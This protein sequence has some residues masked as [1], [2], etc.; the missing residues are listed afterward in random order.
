MV[1]IADIVLDSPLL[2][3]PLAG[4]TDLP[5]RLLCREFGAGLVFSEMISCHGLVHRQKKT[6]AMLRSSAGE[7][8]VAFQLFGNDPDIMA[9]AAALLAD[10][11][12]DIIDI[13]MGCPVRKVTKKGAGAALLADP[14]RA[15]KIIKKVRDAARMPVTVKIRSGVDNNKINCVDFARMAE[16]AGAAA[17]TLHPRTWVQAFKGKAD[18]EL[19]RAVKEQLTIPVIGNGDI[20]TPADAIRMRKLTGCDAAMIGRGALGNPWIFRGE[21]RPA[22]PSPRLE[23]L[24]RHLQ[25]ARHYPDPDKVLF[26]LKNHACRYFTALPGATR[27]RNEIF[28]CPSF[29]SLRRLVEELASQAAASIP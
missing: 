6:L 24:R 9:E 4:Y 16:D 5:F 22:V 11:P 15:D 28:A 20:L 2:Q 18:W 7:R 12:I 25:L 17:V 19:I 26:R 1:T 29:S 13:N 23:A 21:Q 8:P 27:L 3:A 14:K 10:L